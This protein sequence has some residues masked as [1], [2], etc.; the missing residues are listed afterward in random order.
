MANYITALK[1]A[2]AC[3]DAEIA[4]MRRELNDF[5]IFLST[6]PKFG[7]R[8]AIGD[9]RDRDGLQVPPPAEPAER[10]DWIATKDVLN[11]IRDIEVAGL[12]A[13]ENPED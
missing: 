6:S 11:R 2:I 7:N 3:K 10:L 4:A 1:A 8:P 5:R 12:L 9:F 13:S